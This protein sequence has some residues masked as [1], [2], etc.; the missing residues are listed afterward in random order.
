L[1]QN[2]ARIFVRS[3]SQFFHPVNQ[4]VHIS[5]MLA[6]I[7]EWLAPQPGWVV[8]D[9]TFGAGGHTAALAQRVLPDGL[10]IAVDRD[11]AAIAVA[12]QR[13]WGLPIKLAHASYRELPQILAEVGHPRVRGIVLDLGLSSDQ[14]ADRERGFSFESEGSL[15]MRF[16]TSAGEPTWQW[17]NRVTEEELAR[18]IFEYGEERYSRR[19]ARRIV[20]VRPEPIKTAKQLAGIVRSAVPRNHNERIDPATRTFQGIRIGVNGELDELEAALRVLPDCLEPGGR[21]AIISFHSLEDRLVKNAMR[22]DLRLNSLTKKPL[23]A[24]EREIN[25]NPRSRSAKLRVAER[26]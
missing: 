9:G 8:A 16:D 25:E 10:V 23:L 14:L 4:P 20:A 26:V 24:S 11:P 21:L 22:D 12:E 3:S 17:L 5:V 19:I 18:V 1:C 6:E 13:R 7:L 15:D 2:S